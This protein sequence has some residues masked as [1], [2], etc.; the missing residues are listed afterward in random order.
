MVPR[1]L[2]GADPG[3]GLPR[4]CPGLRRVAGMARIAQCQAAPSNI[5][6]DQAMQTTDKECP[7]E[8]GGGQSTRNLPRETQP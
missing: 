3:P 7:A 5:K 4:G 1:R 8:Y 2:L 6:Q